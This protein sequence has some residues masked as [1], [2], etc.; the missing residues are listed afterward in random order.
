MTIR[1]KIAVLVIVLLL[2]STISGALTEP[3][4]DM[5]ENWLQNSRS[6]IMMKNLPKNANYTW[7]EYFSSWNLVYEKEMARKELSFSAANYI[8]T[9]LPISI[10]WTKP[11]AI[12][13]SVSLRTCGN[14]TKWTSLYKGS[15]RVK[16]DS[17]L[18]HV[19][20]AK[21]CG[22]EIIGQWCGMGN[23]LS[24]KMQGNY[25]LHAIIHGVN[26]TFT[27]PFS[28]YHGLKDAVIVETK[29]SWHFT[30]FFVATV[31]AL[32]AV[33]LIMIV[34][35]VV[36]LCEKTNRKLSQM[37]S[38]DHWAKLGY[39]VDYYRFDGPEGD[40]DDVGSVENGNENDD[41]EHRNHD[42]NETKT[43]AE[44]TIEDDGVVVYTPRRK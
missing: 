2:K 37:A 15:H 34:A 4:F 7:R 33:T 6:I 17:R 39:S 35:G 31:F 26:V 40:P 19:W 22:T 10:N 12:Y 44:I 9:E 20:S 30:R 43:E 32:I 27:C 5:Y 29:D 1:L 28:L 11:S 13:L 8:E 14:E 42:S 18:H 41:N 25:T 38:N 23:R 24:I 16:Y 36:F 21:Y 3:D